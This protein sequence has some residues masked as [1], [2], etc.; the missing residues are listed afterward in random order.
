MFDYIIVGQGIAGSVLGWKLL[1]AGKSILVINNEQTNQASHVAAGIYNPITGR[2]LAKTWLADQLFPALIQFYKTVETDLLTTFLYPKPIFV[3]FV[4]NEVKSIWETKFL[5]GYY[6]NFCI[7]V[8]EHYH[9]EQVFNY[10]GGFLVEQTG[11]IDVPCFIQ[12]IKKYLQTK[13]VYIEADFDHNKICLSNQHV[14]YKGIQATKIIFCEG[15]QAKQNP[16]FKYL[17]FR[18]VKGELLTVKPV[19]PIDIIYNKGVFALP[20]VKQQV[21]IGATYNWE[22]LSL[23]VTEKAKQELEGKLQKLLRTSYKI[24]NQQVG[25]RPATFDR[26]PWIGMH[27]QYPQVGIFNGL[28]TKGV[29]LAPYL[30]DEF[31]QY[32]LYGKSLPAEVRLDR[33]GGIGIC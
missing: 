27:P 14:V 1:K 22:D 13:G 6:K 5:E 30:A 18:L 20:T 19:V 9:K 23:I 7:S 24:I 16:F 3:P 32:L 8:D 21:V 12:S 4:N 29:S 11:Y 28:G 2:H 25:I 31:V 10:Y 15:A 17:P 33:V 26:R